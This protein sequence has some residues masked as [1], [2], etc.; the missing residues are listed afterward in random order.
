MPAPT[1]AN[2]QDFDS[3]PR[4]CKCFLLTFYCHASLPR[5]NASLHLIIPKTNAAQLDL[6]LPHDVKSHTLEERSRGDARLGEQPAHT[7]PACLCLKPLKQ[8]S[9]HT[10]TLK[11]VIH[12]KQI[13]VSACTQTAKTDYTSC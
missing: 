9:S 4:C 7:V 1:P 5:L 6:L 13:N 12:V 2:V 11:T 8:L 3:P 10:L